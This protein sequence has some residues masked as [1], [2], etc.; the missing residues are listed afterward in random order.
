[1][2]LNQECILLQSELRKFAQ[3]VILEKVD[4]LDKAGSLPLDN[5]KQLADMGILGA[6]IPE[7][8][9]GAALDLIGFVVSLEEISKVCTSTAIVV[10]THMTP[11]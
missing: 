9:G 5:I 8:M 10:A 11:R 2:E 4:E 7:D 3:Q 6:V 1:M